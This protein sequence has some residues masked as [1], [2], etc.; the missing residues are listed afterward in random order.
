MEDEPD[1]DELALPDAARVA[2]RALVLAAVT[3]RGMMESD[4][5]RQQGEDRRRQM[6]RWL[7]RIGV[8]AELE[9]SEAVLIWTPLGQLDQQDM[10]DAIWRC[11]GMLV[12]AW[13]MG[14]ADLLRHDEECDPFEVAENLGFLAERGETV[15][16]GPSL[17]DSDD[18]ARQ[19]L[20]CLTVHWRLR[21]YSL[22]PSAI[23]FASHVE[24]CNW[25]P[26]TIS[27]LDLVDGDLGI[28]G[29]R[30]DRAP[31]DRYRRTMSIAQERHQA[32]NWLVGAGSTYSHVRTDT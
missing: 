7:E 21:Q 6:C 16:A 23:D 29:E 11:E 30:I 15:L 25:G 32:F 1:E 17:R 12:L 2:A 19:T 3:C 10:I 22:E 8:T 20:A 24:H 4:E 27:H 26:L 13:S 9:E 18:I 31:E 5:D 28:G 14:R